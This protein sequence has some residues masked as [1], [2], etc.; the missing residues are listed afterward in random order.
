[1]LI[2]C[3][4]PHYILPSTVCNGWGMSPPIRERRP[5]A[6]NVPIIPLHLPGG[7]F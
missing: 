5:L 4:K 7:H 2:P 3:V 6:E 1:M